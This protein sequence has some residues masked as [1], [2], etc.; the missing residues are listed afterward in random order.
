MVAKNGCL[1]VIQ[2][3]SAASALAPEHAERFLMFLPGAVPFA[4]IRDYPR[5]SAVRISGYQAGR[6]FF[7]GSGSG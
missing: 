3:F 4:S 2:W 1:N 7:R 6:W 5:E